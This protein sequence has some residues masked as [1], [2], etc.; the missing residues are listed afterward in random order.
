M[1]LILC[2]DKFAYKVKHVGNTKFVVHL[3][4]QDPQTNSVT[5]NNEST[6][7]NIVPTVHVLKGHKQSL[8]MKDL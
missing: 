5:N 4:P 2:F 3:Y 8:F 1:Y 7:P 6:E